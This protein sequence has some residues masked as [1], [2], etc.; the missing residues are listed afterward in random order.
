MNFSLFFSLNKI[1]FCYYAVCYL[2][3]DS[4]GVTSH[5]SQHNLCLRSFGFRLQ[6][7]ETPTEYHRGRGV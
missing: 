2:N 1:D 3:G 7:E 5:T 6:D 4:V